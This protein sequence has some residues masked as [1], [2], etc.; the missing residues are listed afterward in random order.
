MIGLILGTSEGKNI[1]SLLNK[2]TEDIFISTATSYGGDILT[3]YKYKTI[4]TK[5]LDID[6]L[7]EL[8]IKHG[9]KALVD[10]SHPYAT[11]IT[12]NS[13][14]ACEDL[15]IEYLRFERPSISDNY[16]NNNKLITAGSYEELIDKIKNIKELQSKD[17]VILNTTGSRNID[18]FMTSN[19][20]NRIVHRVLPSSEVIKECL[21]L[22]VAIEDII[23]IKGPIGFDL[24]LGFI[25]QYKAKGIILKDSG[26]LGG[27][28][29]KIMAAL[30]E[31]IYI[32]VIERKKE[33]FKNIFYSEKQLVEFIKENNLY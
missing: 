18:K 25:K 20:I 27:T 28:E 24:N 30:H 19:L 10:A 6:G 8:F 7:K 14:K 32:F 9:I 4:N 11:E 12:K 13:Q 33:Q 29:E 1:L 26:V 17:S 21:E 2:F 5:P 3:E 31:D 22:G 15:K 23:T 16:L